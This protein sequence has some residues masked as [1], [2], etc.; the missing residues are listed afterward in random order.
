MN[1]IECIKNI[2]QYLLEQ[3]ENKVNFLNR[4]TLDIYGVNATKDQAISIYKSFLD[5]D[6]ESM[7]YIDGNI[8]KIDY[9]SLM[10]EAKKW[11]I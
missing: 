10:K 4:C 9:K 2:K 6:L 7:I 8:F 5:K 1:R 11:L 3:V